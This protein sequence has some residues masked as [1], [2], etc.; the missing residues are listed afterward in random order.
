MLFLLLLLNICAANGAVY[1]YLT[2]V[3]NYFGYN[4]GNENSAAEFSQTVPYE[5]STVDQ[6]FIEE[7]VKLTG[8]AISELDSC[9]QR[10]ILKLK[11]DCN[12]LNDEQLAKVAVHLLNCQSYIE[13]RKIYP[14]TEEMSIKECTTNMDSDTW[15]SYHLMSNR[16]RSV[17]YM[18]RQSQFR[19]LAEHTVNRLMEASKDQLKSLG[20]ITLNQETIKN[21]AES[22]Y[23]TLNKAHKHLSEQQR[24]MQKAQL[25]GQ[26]VLENNIIRLIDEKRLIHETHE[27]LVQMTKDVQSR[28]DMSA[29]LL[30]NQNIESR[31]NHKELLDDLT[32]LH[33]KAVDLFKKIDDYSE[34]LLTQNK[35]FQKQYQDTLRNLQEVNRTVHDLVGLLGGTRQ[36]L[37]DRLSWIMTALGGTDSAVERIYIIFWHISF[38]LVAM[39]SCAFLSARTSTRLVI[40]TLPPMNM[41][42]ALYSREHL[43]PVTLG[44]VIGIFVCIQ[45]FIISAVNIRGRINGAISWSKSETSQKKYGSESPNLHDLDIGSEADVYDYQSNFESRELDVNDRFEYQSLTPPRSRVGTYSVRSRSRSATPL[46]LNASSRSACHAKTRTGT[47]CRITSMP[48]RDFCYRHQNGDSVLG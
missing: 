31:V 20:E 6:K 8:V 27:E 7:A 3:K 10:V 16:A 11:S 41:I 39:L 35:N 26:L 46:V 13:G 36:A 2:S 42:V 22:T 25:H 9:Q 30:Q 18:I 19:G 15:T 5:V 29:E 48:G 37:E 17:C 34:I 47:P 32:G 23:E 24:D 33:Q 1:D 40:A 14:C 43:E 28:L 44:I 38:M 21:V 4:G 12:K 45:T